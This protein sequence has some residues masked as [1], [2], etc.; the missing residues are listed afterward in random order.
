MAE[1]IVWAEELKLSGGVATGILA[2]DLLGDTIKGFI[3][4]LLPMIPPEWLDVITEAG[5]GLFFLYAGYKWVVSPFWKNFIKQAGRAGIGL[6]IR[7]LVL[8]YIK[9]ALV[10]GRK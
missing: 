10:G 5:V 7:N 1:P 3:G 6:A 8:P 9:A 4:K 2:I